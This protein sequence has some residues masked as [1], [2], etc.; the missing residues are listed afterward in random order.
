MKTARCPQ[1]KQCRFCRGSHHHCR[2]SQLIQHVPVHDMY[3]TD[4]PNGDCLCYTTT[5]TLFESA[6]GWTYTVYE[7]EVRREALCL[8]Y[9]VLTSMPTFTTTD[10]SPGTCFFTHMQTCPPL[11]VQSQDLIA[12]TAASFRNRQSV[13]EGKLYALSV[14]LELP[15]AASIAAAAS[16]KPLNST[17]YALLVT[18]PAGGANNVVYRRTS[19]R[20][21]LKPASLK[22]PVVQQNGDL[23][24]ARVPMPLYASK[25]STR[26][27]K[28]WCVYV[29]VCGR[30]GGGGVD[31][32]VDDVQSSSD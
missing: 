9:R 30:G 21:A 17:D 23:L 2:N 7:P 31:Q 5:C 10:P 18:V 16:K 24:W 15:A 1:C 28:V 12:I 25:N 4:P 26:L 8:A 27:F 13:R 14:K 3:I 11:V 22:K 20:P 32:D 19:V 6:P 29:C